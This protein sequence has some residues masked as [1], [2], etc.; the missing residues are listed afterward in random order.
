MLPGLRNSLVCFL[1]LYVLFV[2]LPGLC[3]AQPYEPPAGIPVL[4]VVVENEFGHD[5]NTFCQGLVFANGL[6][7]ESSGRYGL[8]HVKAYELESARVVF[9]HNLPERFFAEGIAVHNEKLVQLTWKSGKGF[10]YLLDGLRGCGQ[11][12]VPATQGWG[13]ACRKG[14]MVMS[15]GTDKLYFLH[16]DSMTVISKKKVRAQNSYLSRLNELEFYHGLLLAN[17]WM[18]N[19]IAVI[20]PESVELVAWVDLTPLVKKIGAKG[21][22]N[23]LNGIAWDSVGDRLLVTGKCWPRIFCIKINGFN[24]IL[25]QRKRLI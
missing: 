24:E 10:M 17:V 12:E 8:S 23:V 6:V 25:A 9:R 13:L 1:P 2:A 22:E 16:P 19:G 18:S 3:F 11:F 15:D 5:T 14:Q 21:R 4:S 20:D 7:Y